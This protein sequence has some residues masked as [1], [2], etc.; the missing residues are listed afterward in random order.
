MRQAMQSEN[1]GTRRGGAYGVAGFV[2]GLGLS[3]LKNY[4]I[5]E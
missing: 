4:E 2:K 1:Y 3:S 5:W